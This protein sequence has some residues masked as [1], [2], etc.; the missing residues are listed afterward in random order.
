VSPVRSALLDAAYDAAVG[1]GWGRTRMGD[2]AAAAGVSRQ[3]L[4]AEFGSKE[5]LAQALA[6]R[7]AARFVDGSEAVLTGH[8]GSPAEAI[9]A[10]TEWT[11]R[12]A[13]EDPLIKAVL[14]DDGT[15]G[16]LP[17][18][19]TRSD[20]LLAAVTARNVDYLRSHWP[21]LPVDDIEFVAD[22][23]VRLTVS[24]IVTPA[25]PAD[26]TARSIAHLVDR[27]LPGGPVQ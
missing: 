3:T 27:L 14:T 24:H 1:T 6:L 2:V 17:Y 26:V 21:D 7:E 18:L 20:A 15:D 8:E 9:A 4:Y 16:L 23:L 10:S 12:V 22:T 19:T 25:G 5:G 13:R 11:L